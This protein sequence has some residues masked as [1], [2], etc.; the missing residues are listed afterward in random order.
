MF[1]R[2]QWKEIYATLASNKL[3][4]SLTAFGV[5]WGII[6][7]IVMLGAGSGLKNGVTSEFDGFAMNSL[8]VWTQNATMPYKGLPA[9]RWF[10]LKNSDTEAII[11]NIPE[12][13]VIA[14]RN[15]LGGFRGTSSVRRKDKTGD[16]RIIGDV[17]E[18]REIQALDIDQGRWMNHLDLN[19]KRKVAIIGNRVASTLFGPNEEIIGDYI[20]LNGVAFKVVGTFKT[21]KAGDEANED[22]T[23]VFVPFSTFQRV[24]NYGDIVSY[25]GFAPKP[26]VPTSVIE[27]KIIDLLKDRHSIHPDD[28]FAFGSNN[29]EEEF[30]EVSQVFSGINFISWL[31]GIATLLAGVIGVSNIMLVIIKERTKEIGIRRAIGAS[32]YQIVKQIMLEAL[33]LTSV[34]GY[35]GVILGVLLVENVGPLIQD[36]AF[37]N[38]EIDFNVALMAVSVLSVAGCFAGLIPAMRALEIKPVEALRTDR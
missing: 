23:T 32:P 25:Y 18:I 31:V 13:E 35:I 14:P 29:N 12:I 22:A 33:I 9:G 20:M 34:A 5:S 4:T 1:D 15:E 17:P 2:D 24:F 8:Y 6:M 30:Q 38:P 11:A 37:K 16:F 19:E 3:R 7:L 28:R 26:G 27:T 21:K 10:N 36:E